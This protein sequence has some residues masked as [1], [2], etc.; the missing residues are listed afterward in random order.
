MGGAPRFSLSDTRR[1][2]E[3]GEVDESWSLIKL[4]LVASLGKDRLILTPQLPFRVGGRWSDRLQK[5]LGT[6]GGP[7]K[8]VRKREGSSD[9]ERGRRTR[10]VVQGT[11]L[12]RV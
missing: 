2:Q 3:R 7:G 5:R 6:T 4:V 8:G 11:F 9:F 1:S 10:E 12:T